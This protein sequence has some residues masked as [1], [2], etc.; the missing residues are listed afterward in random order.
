ML[1]Y[2]RKQ[3][4]GMNNT[5]NSAIHVDIPRGVRSRYGGLI[6]DGNHRIAGSNNDSNYVIGGNNDSNHR[7]A[8]STGIHAKYRDINYVEPHHYSSKERDEELEKIN[9]NLQKNDGKYLEDTV[10]G[11]NF[12][13]DLVSIPVRFL[14]GVAGMGLQEEED[15]NGHGFIDDMSHSIGSIFGSIFGGSAKQYKVTIDPNKLHESLVMLMGRISKIEEVLEIPYTREDHA[16]F[17]QYYASLQPKKGG[18]I[19]NKNLLGGDPVSLPP[20]SLKLS[21]DDF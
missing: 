18:E 1:Y 14:H 6:Y 20:S 3:Y 17:K 7:I 15:I 8:G 10:D 2:M 4:K 21:V 9:K 5:L 16:N 12:F 19:A 11:G 13:Q